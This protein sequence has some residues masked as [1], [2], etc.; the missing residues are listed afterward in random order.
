MQSFDVCVI[1]AD[2]GFGSL[3]ITASGAMIG[4]DTTPRTA[5]A[6]AAIARAGTRV[7]LAVAAARLEPT[8]ALMPPV[9]AIRHVGAECEPWL[10]RLASEAPA[11]RLIIV[12]ADGAVRARARALGFAVAPHVELALWLSQGR[13]P[14]FAR[15][16]GAHQLLEQASDLLAYELEAS[17]D[18]LTLWAALPDD[19][20]QRLARSGAHV[21]LLKLDIALS[22]PYL[23]RGPGCSAVGAD[24]LVWRQRGSCLL[25]VPP[26]EPAAL[27][28]LASR[29]GAITRLAPSP[30]LLVDRAAR[31]ATRLTL[32]PEPPAPLHG[33][34][35]G[36]TVS[37]I[38]HDVARFSGATALDEHGA[39]SSRH[40]DHPHSARV[41]AALTRDLRELGLN[42]QAHPFAYQGRS[43]VNLSAELPG[44]GL[45]RVSPEVVACMRAGLTEPER[46]MRM[47]SAMNRAQPGEPASSGVLDLADLERQLGLGGWTGWWRDGPT[48][49]GSGA[50]LIIV[51][52][53]FDSTAAASPN[54][55]PTTSP[56]PGADDDASGIAC[57]L[58]V[59]RELV[60]YRDVLRHSVRL[61]FFNAEE[62]GLVGS[63]AAGPT[64]RS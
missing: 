30:E 15:V 2:Q 17:G 1:V 57:V 41:V 35:A 53:H 59:A 12:A 23:L 11:R 40:I 20:V 43:Y 33:G 22:D 62:Q 25:A 34:Y 45:Q 29:H 10:K 6:L 58:A 47:L 61:C 21:E 18:E 63:Q 38:E 48:V 64:P 28:S 49:A 9:A 55:H 14:R 39:I 26:S 44:V 37:G 36:P 52:A 7:E 16:R 32:Q 54:Y 4:L 60:K 3:R 19:A 8:P 5:R 24:Q 27:E 13:S 42:P 51:A 50:E 56:A 31:R 46:A